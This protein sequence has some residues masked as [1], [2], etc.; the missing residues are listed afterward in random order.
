MHFNKLHFMTRGKL[1]THPV[2]IL[3]FMSDKLIPRHRNEAGSAD[4]FFRS[5]L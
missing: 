2:Q 5:G 3:L 4:M 1:I